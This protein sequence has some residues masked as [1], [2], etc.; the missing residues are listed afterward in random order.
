MY[1]TAILSIGF[2]TFLVTPLLAI[3][4][5]CASIT[6]LQKQYHCLRYKTAVFTHGSTGN[7]LM[8]DFKEVAAIVYDGSGMFKYSHFNEN[9][10]FLVDTI[11]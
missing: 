7:N 5:S 3:T 9:T 11:G 6:P 2:L 8:L 10:N 4:N 1:R